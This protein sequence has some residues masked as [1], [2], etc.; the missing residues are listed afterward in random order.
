M[1]AE[2][3]PSNLGEILDRTAQMYRSHFPLYF[4]IAAICYSGVLVL[5]LIANAVLLPRY[6]GN[7]AHL[8]QV[9]VVVSL[10]IGVISILPIAIAMAA[11][12]RAV[13]A[14]YLGQTSTIGQAYAG[15]G[16]KW[17]RYILILLAMYCYAMLPA[18]CLTGAM[19]AAI[20]FTQPGFGR[21]L[22]IGTM[23][24][25][26]LVAFVFA[27]LWM[28]RWLLA[29]PSSLMEDLPVH[30][31]LKR[32]AV[33][34][35]GARGRIFVMLL[36]VGA[37]MMVIQY[38][39]QIPMFFMLWKSKGSPTMAT[40]VLSSFG[41]FLS[42]SFVMPIYSIAITLFYYDQRIRKEGYDVEWLMDQ[43]AMPATP[44]TM[45]PAAKSGSAT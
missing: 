6:R 7:A 21:N 14:N 4:G 12:I 41:T 37:V 43:A 8:N 26:V 33:L 5:S 38:A 34:T 9:A 3:R 24:V 2:L 30:R 20:G 16:R 39:V 42:G 22:W 36:L 18:I 40:Q 10:V 19:G 35:R 27:F 32:S 28:L 1:R 13:A 45:S 15:I 44:D 31:S 11:I 29:V 25:L 17:Y 23:G